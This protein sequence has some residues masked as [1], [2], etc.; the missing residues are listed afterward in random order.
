MGR[1]RYRNITIDSDKSWSWSITPSY[2]TDT[3]K[4]WK[5]RKVVYENTYGY[6]SHSKY[7]IT[8][9]LIARFIK[10]YLI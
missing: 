4:I 2:Y 5:D 3:L 9:S 8:P 7:P 10:R 1:K 6:Y